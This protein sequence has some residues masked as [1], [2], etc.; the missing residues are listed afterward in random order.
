MFGSDES[1]EEIKLRHRAEF[2]EHILQHVW[3]HAPNCVIDAVNTYTRVMPEDY[4]PMWFKTVKHDCRKI[5]GQVNVNNIPRFV[6]E[7]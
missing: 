6:R 7:D 3:K 1:W 5:K 2:L 4:Q